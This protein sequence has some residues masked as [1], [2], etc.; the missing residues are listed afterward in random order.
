MF[1]HFGDFQ[2]GAMPIYEYRC[3]D[4]GTVF[5]KIVSLS[6]ESA[7]C[8]QCSG[9]NL[10]KLFSTFAVQTHHYAPCGAGREACGGCSAGRPSLCGET[11]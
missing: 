8:T 5:E 9:S 7:D 6:A 3:R 10:E 1:A 11:N 4:C 2:G